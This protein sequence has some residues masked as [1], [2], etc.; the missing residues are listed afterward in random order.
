MPSLVAPTTNVNGMPT[1]IRFEASQLPSGKRATIPI[2]TFDQLEQY[3][4]QTLKLK[5]RTLVET[6]GEG[7]VPPLAGKSTQQ[8]LISYI[9]DI[10]ISLCATIGLRVG[11]YHFGTPTDWTSADDS[12]YFG[13]DGKLASHHHNFL[14]ADYRKPMQSIQPAHRELDHRAAIEVNQAEA[15]M[16][17]HASKARNQGSIRLG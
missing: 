10:Q 13:G 4:L 1:E 11:I 16:G 6:I 3:P 14:E 8:Q 7:A 2:Y 17:F 15:T 12:G 9:L 5:A